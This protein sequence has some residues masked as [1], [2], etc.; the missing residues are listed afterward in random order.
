[1]W[2][3][4]KMT[5]KK[6]FKKFAKQGKKALL[7]TRLDEDN[8]SEVQAQVHTVNAL[9]KKLPKNL[10]VKKKGLIFATA[11]RFKNGEF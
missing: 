6:H 11:F 9:K 5:K 8:G 10:V 3:Q 1:M 4:C 2:F 7:C